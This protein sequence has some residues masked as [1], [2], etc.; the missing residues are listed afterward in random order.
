MK[1]IFIRTNTEL[2]HDVSLHDLHYRASLQLIVKVT[3]KYF[4]VS[5]H[6]RGLRG[7]TLFALVTM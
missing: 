7:F 6:G 5:R 1:S 4:T 2:P 3:V